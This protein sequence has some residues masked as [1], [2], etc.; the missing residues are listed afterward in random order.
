[1]EL[2]YNQMHHH[3]FLRYFCNRSIVCRLYRRRQVQRLR[4]CT[5]LFN[6]NE[7]S[8]IQVN[9]DPK[10]VKIVVII[11]HYVMTICMVKSPAAV[12]SCL[13]TTNNPSAEEYPQR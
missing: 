1:M 10:P 2:Y 11:R 4:I 13:S 5:V 8:A 9:I 3:A 6:T 7:Q 12:A